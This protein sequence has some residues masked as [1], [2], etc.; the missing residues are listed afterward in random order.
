[1]STD[2]TGAYLYAGA[3]ATAVPGPKG[4]VAVCTIGSTNALTAVTG[5][6]FTTG[7]GN[8]GVAASNVVQ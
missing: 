1:M 2:I 4:D 7:T 5:S 6:P 8:A 3:K